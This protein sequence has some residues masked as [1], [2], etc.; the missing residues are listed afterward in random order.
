MG[1]GFDGV[2]AVAV[3]TLP[4]APSTALEHYLRPRAALWTFHSVQV[5]T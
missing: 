3:R 2:E 1:L 4:P 5:N